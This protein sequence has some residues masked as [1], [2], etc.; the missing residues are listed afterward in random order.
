MEALRSHTPPEVAEVPPR[1]SL[2][3]RLWDDMGDQDTEEPQRKRWRTTR[4]RALPDPSNIDAGVRS[5]VGSN[6]AVSEDVSYAS[7]V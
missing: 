7:L 3:R 5:T 2:G 1:L 4:S 6:D